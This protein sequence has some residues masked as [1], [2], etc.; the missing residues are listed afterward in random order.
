MD[1]Y[2]LCQLFDLVYWRVRL[3]RKLI[4]V[5][6]GSIHLDHFVIYKEFCWRCIVS[7]LLPWIQLQYV[8]YCSQYVNISC[9]GVAFC[10]PTFRYGNDVKLHFEETEKRF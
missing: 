10:D 7:N 5:V 2:R 4:Q 8:L 3:Q 6:L 1:V 9:Q